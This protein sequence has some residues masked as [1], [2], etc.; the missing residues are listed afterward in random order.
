MYGGGY[1]DI[2]LS[3]FLPAGLR[4]LSQCGVSH[5]ACYGIRMI[6]YMN[7]DSKSVKVSKVVVIC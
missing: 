5:L 1:C 2:G 4:N 3:P 7:D 6:R